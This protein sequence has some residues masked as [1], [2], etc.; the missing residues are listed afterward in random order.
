MISHWADT[1]FVNDVLDLTATASSGLEVSYELVSGAAD[2]DTDALT[3][4]PT[5]EGTIEIKASQAGDEAFNAA[6]DVILTVTA[7]KRDQTIEFTLVDTTFVNNVLDLTA[8]ASSGLDVTYEIVS[9]NATLDTDANTLTPTTE[10]SVEIK[11]I[12]AGN[13]EYNAATEIILTVIAIKQDQSIS[14]TLTDTAFVNEVLDLTAT[15]TSGL[16]ITYELVS[17]NAILDT[18]AM[19]LTPSAEGTIQIKASQA[20]DVAYNAATDVILTVTAIKQ[21]QS[22]EFT[23][24]D[25]AYVNDV[26]CSKCDCNFRFRYY[27]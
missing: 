5:A 9:G 15:A 24:V 6:T 22:I 1:A 19:T 2:L 4:T 27:I 13:V 26:S 20:G 23:L 7:I 14:F 8:T 16:D 18:D 17:G 10:G 3:L 25:T 21:D 11:A 12:Q